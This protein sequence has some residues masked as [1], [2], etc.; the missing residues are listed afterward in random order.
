MKTEEEIRDELDRIN[1]LL[2]YNCD[3][4]RNGYFGVEQYAKKEMLQWVLSE[5]DE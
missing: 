5:E 4:A 2:H 3:A 1:R